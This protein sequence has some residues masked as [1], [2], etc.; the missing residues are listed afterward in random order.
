MVVYLN[1]KCSILM[2]TPCQIIIHKMALV[3]CADTNNFSQ[4]STTGVLLISTFSI[5]NP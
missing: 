5:F 4:V 1:K 2:C 3:V